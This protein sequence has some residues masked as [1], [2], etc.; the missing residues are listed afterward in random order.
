[1]GAGHEYGSLD[2]GREKKI[3]F[4]LRAFTSKYVVIIEKEATRK[5]RK[6][7]IHAP[8]LGGEKISSVKRSKGKSRLGA[9][10]L[11][12]REKKS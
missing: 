11:G 4:I 6:D 3:N 2:T 12:V 9:E 8:H 5:R 10:A 1:M 7:I